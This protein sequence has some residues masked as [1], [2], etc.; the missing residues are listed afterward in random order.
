MF[1]EIPCPSLHRSAISGQSSITRPD[2]PDVDW[3]LERIKSIN[4]QEIEAINS[5]NLIDNAVSS[6]SSKS[7]FK[8]LSA[9]EIK[10]AKEL[11]LQVEDMLVEDGGRGGR[12]GRGLLNLFANLADLRQDSGLV[13][14]GNSTG[15]ESRGILEFV[16]EVAGSILG[17]VGQG[18]TLKQ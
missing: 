9:S 2:K 5:K 10:E 17:R 7:D 16:S 6:V 1:L 18:V 11:L 14:G 12:S 3:I 13:R 15:D 8:H 4:K